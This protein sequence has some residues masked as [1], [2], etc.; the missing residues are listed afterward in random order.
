MGLMPLI[1][2]PVL[3]AISTLLLQGHG[4]AVIMDLGLLY[5]D[6]AYAV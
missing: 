6:G 4:Q 3:Q 1:M 2:P 5:V